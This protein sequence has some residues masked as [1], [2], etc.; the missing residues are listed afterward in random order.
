[1][2]LENP[3][4]K[5]DPRESSENLPEIPK[6]GDYVTAKMVDVLDTRQG[7]FIKDNGDG[8]ILVQGSLETY[9]CEGPEGVIVVPDSSLRWDE[10]TMKHVDTVRKNLAA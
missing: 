4:R 10:D 2:S 9:V 8:T 1:M 5:I 3:S 7:V 6:I